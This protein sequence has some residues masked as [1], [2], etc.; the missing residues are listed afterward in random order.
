MTYK[1]GD[2]VECRHDEDWQRKHCQSDKDKAIK[3]GKP[4]SLFVGNAAA[5]MHP[6]E[7]YVIVAITPTGG[8]RLRG[9]VPQVC[10]APDD[11]QPSTKPSYR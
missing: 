5:Y 7:A 1:I 10:C 3:L 9:F 4:G 11:V 2:R 6:D 8:L